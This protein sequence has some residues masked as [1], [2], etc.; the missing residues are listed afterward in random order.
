MIK[1]MKKLQ[2]IGPK[3]LLDE[4]IKTLHEMA[5]VHIETVP[6]D[7]GAGEAFL[8][9]FPLEAEK[10]KEKEFLDKA[11]DEL[12]NMML[13]LPPPQSYRTVRVASAELYKFLDEISPAGKEVKA[14]CARK[15]ELKDELSVAERY[16]RLLRGFVPIVP[17]LGGLKNFDIVGLTIERSRADVPKLMENEVMRITEGSYRMYTVD[18]DETTTGVVLTYP[19]K[20]DPEIRRLLTGKSI[21]ELRLPDKYADMPLIEAL[22]EMERKKASL[23]GLIDETENSLKRISDRWY[24]TIAGLTRAIEDALDEIGALTYVAETR[25]AFVIEGW[26]PAENFGPLKERFS[27]D[28]GGRVFVRELDITGEE[29]EKGLVP[30]YIRNPDFLR[31]FEIFLSAVPPPKYGSVDP[32]PYL[33]VFFPAFFGLIVGDIGYGAVLF[34][35]SLYV[36]R[37]FKEKVFL[38][39]LSIVLSVCSLSAIAFGFLF[40]EF[41]GDLGGRLGFIHP[42]LFHRAEALKTMLI[43]TLGIGAGH[44]ILG[45]LIGA[46]NHLYRR[47][48]REAGGKIA[49]LAIIFSLFVIFGVYYGNVPRVLLTPLVVAAV[50]AFVILIALEGIIGP[51]EFIKA[52]GNML[53]YL[54]LMAVGTASV[55]M[56]IVANKIGGATGNLALGI[57]AGALLHLLNIALSLLSPV[58]QSMRL[59]Y[60]EFF[61]KFY[62]GG[63]RRYKPFKKR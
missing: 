33:A 47:R 28:Y 45:L 37:R 48:R 26:A 52:L 31:P 56:A 4:C 9:R 34:L 18:F 21:S 27:R 22:K 2:I 5:V 8:R 44:V 1:E 25:F 55:V 10:L 29:K 62:E 6:A 51:L 17:R 11:A 63:G 39:D 13:L 24:G 43:L 40:G 35:L 53:S 60:V 20:F 15:D 32:T 30:V 61:S 3:T 50:A 49:S 14:L 23:P 36:R 46:I 42:I 57:F 16:E 19:R 54:R 7:I 41:F 12:R 38:R 58:I 59:Q